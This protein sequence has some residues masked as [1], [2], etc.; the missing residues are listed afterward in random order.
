MTDVSSCFKPGDMVGLAG[1]LFVSRHSDGWLMNGRMCTGVC[2]C[3][4]KD[5]HVW[6]LYL[7]FADCSF[8]GHRKRHLFLRP[9]GD[10]CWRYYSSRMR[11]L[12]SSDG[13][14]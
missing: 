14:L 5:T 9:E 13:M 2:S 7:G 1:V 8:Y 12:V 3:W 4:S 10:V 11:V 6:L